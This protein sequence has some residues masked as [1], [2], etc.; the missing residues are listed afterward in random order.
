MQFFHL[1]RCCAVKVAINASHEAG[2]ISRAPEPHPSLWSRKEVTSVLTCHSCL[3]LGFGS[4]SEGSSALRRQGR[5]YTNPP[6]L[7]GGWQERWRGTFSRECSD[8]KRGNCFKLKESRFT[9][10]RKKTFF[11][12]RMMKHCNRLLRGVVGA[13]S[14]GTFKV[15]LGNALSNLIYLKMSLLTVGLLN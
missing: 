5:P 12:P 6:V 8:R 10:D 14:L 4:T 7:K 2:R 9:L 1:A 11:S 3:K 13:P 15:R